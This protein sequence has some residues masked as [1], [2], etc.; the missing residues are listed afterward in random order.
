MMQCGLL[1]ATDVSEEHVAFFFLMVWV[2]RET[3]Q[4]VKKEAKAPQKKSVT[5]YQSIKYSS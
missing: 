3:I 4:T 2:V 1:N 5:T